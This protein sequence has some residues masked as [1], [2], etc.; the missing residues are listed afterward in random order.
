MGAVGRQIRK[1]IPRTYSQFKKLTGGKPY[2]ERG[3]GLG[4]N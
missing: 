3:T 4:D 1:L 2:Q